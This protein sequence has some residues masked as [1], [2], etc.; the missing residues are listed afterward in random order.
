MRTVAFC[1]VAAALV[2]SEVGCVSGPPVNAVD[3]KAPQIVLRGLEPQPLDEKDGVAVLKTHQS[4]RLVADV[5]KR[6][7]PIVKAERRLSWWGGPWPSGSMGFRAVDLTKIPDCCIR[8]YTS[9]YFSLP[10]EGTGQT[11][12]I[13]MWVIDAEGRQSNRV[14]LKVVSRQLY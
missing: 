10:N 9:W 6:D 7:A 13:E 11:A 2:L 3:A 5:V 12:E 1:I 14:N 4:Y 8:V